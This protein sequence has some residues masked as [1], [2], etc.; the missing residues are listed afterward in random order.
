MPEPS[1]NGYSALYYALKNRNQ[2]LIKLLLET[3]NIDVNSIG[4]TSALHYACE[5]GNLEAVKYLIEVKRV[6]TSNR[7]KENRTPYGVADKYNRTDIVNYL[8]SKG[9][10]Q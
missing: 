4:P 1:M 3:P 9:I 5:L 8:R 7:D 10:N 6:N 2:D